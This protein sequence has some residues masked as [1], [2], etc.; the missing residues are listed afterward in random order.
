MAGLS[1]K[2]IH[3]HNHKDCYGAHIPPIYTSVVY[4]YIDYELKEAQFIDR[5]NVLRYGREENPTTRALEHVIAKLEETEDALAF[6]SGMSAISTLF[7]WKLEPNTKIVVPMELYSTTFVLL[8]KLALKLNVRVE[9]VHPSA[10][11]IAEAVDSSTSMVFLEV[12]TNPTNK[13]IDLEHLAQSIDTDKIVLVVDNTFTTPVLVKPTK[14]KAKFVLHSMTKYIG[15]HNDAIGGAIASSS[16]D[17]TTL[18]DWR[19][20]LG[21][22]LQPFEAYL[23]LRGIKTLELRFE[24]HSNNAKAIADF[25][26][27]H[28]KIEEV[29]YPGLRE[30]PYHSLAKKLFEKQL[31]GGVVSFKIKGSYQDAVNFVRRLRLIKRCPSLGG[32]ESMIVIPIKAGSMHIEPENRVKLGITENL[33]RLAVGLENVEDL[34]EDIS[35]A[36]NF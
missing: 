9:K 21:G 26:A 35:Q 31:F 8:N 12:M 25:L 3:G 15:G 13:V 32:T 10:K 1:T 11:A 22:I 29:M 20:T 36:L 16:K 17:A 23:I 24:K 34:I 5:G 27:E 19:R 6:N 18:W 2:S 28:S 30:N 33:L 7:L 14:Y 4:E